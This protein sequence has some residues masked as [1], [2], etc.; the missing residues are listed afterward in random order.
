MR[1][2]LPAASG[3]FLAVTAFAQDDQRFGST[4]AGEAR[5]IW[6]WFTPK[7][8]VATRSLLLLSPRE[9]A[10]AVDRD[11]RRA[12]QQIAS[13]QT[14]I[15]R[16]YEERGRRK[17]AAWE[18]N[19]AMKDEDARLRAQELADEKRTASLPPLAG[20]APPEAPQGRVQRLLQQ[21]AVQKV[22]ENTRRL[23]D[24]VAEAVDEKVVQPLVMHSRRLATGHF[25]L[26]LAG[27]FLVPSIGLA[28]LFLG[29]LSFRARHLRKALFFFLI[30]G[31]CTY[32][33]VTALDSPLARGGGKDTAVL[34]PD[35]MELAGKSFAGVE[36][37]SHDARWLNF[38]HTGGASSVPLAELPPVWQQ[39]L[40][41][42]PERAAAE[43]LRSS[44]AAVRAERLRSVEATAILVNATIV[45]EADGGF[46]VADLVPDMSG[47][48]S[49]AISDSGCAFVLTRMKG[50]KP[51][52]ELKLRLFRHGERRIAGGWGTPEVMP[53]YTDSAEQ[54]VD[55][56]PADGSS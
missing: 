53:T 56:M 2:L 45:R 13:D 27:V 39:Q 44:A 54:L 43:D 17:V 49:L 52:T 14:E 8:R 5:G 40:G 32:A 7:D 48:S 28:S 37:D 9:A 50:L 30:A 10:R 36:Y 55:E 29:F 22:S 26:L 24:D 21:P 1:W 33:V 15:R 34:L 6:R 18:A 31:L 46:V 42:D 25:I 16:F 20:A 51:G 4:S 47:A 3:I 12:A 38:R 41:Y 11:H 19:W 35:K 23:V